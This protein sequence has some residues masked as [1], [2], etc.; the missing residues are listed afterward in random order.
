MMF[1]L[2]LIA[3]Q[4]FLRGLS[5][6]LAVEAPS[7]V[8]AQSFV[9]DGGAMSR[10][11]PHGETRWCVRRGSRSSRADPEMRRWSNGADARRIVPKC[12]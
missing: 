8:K 4:L 1:A 3:V 10:R 9:H 5:D 7:T 11:T 2:R 12:L 6:L